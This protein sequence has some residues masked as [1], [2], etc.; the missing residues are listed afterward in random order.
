MLVE[1]VTYIAPWYALEKGGRRIK[2]KIKSIIPWSRRLLLV[3]LDAACVLAAY[4]ATLAFRFGGIVPETYW[5]TFEHSILYIILIYLCV[6]ALFRLYST[7]W[8][9]ASIEELLYVIGA[10]II[11][12]VLCYA[13][14]AIR[15]NRMPRSIYIAAGLIIILLHG[16]L[17]LSY[18][19]F[20]RLLK[21]SIFAHDKIPVLIIGA[22]DAGASII[23]QMQETTSVALIPVCIVDDDIEKR[24]VR[25]HGVRV[26][27]GTDDI[28]VLVKKYGIRQIIYAI[29]SADRIAKRRVLEICTATD[30][31]L[32]II[33]TMETIL[34]GKSD[35]RQLRDVDVGDLLE[36]PIVQ[37]D[38]EAISGY[39][40]GSTVLVTG[41]GGS[42][43]SELCRQ[44]AK[45][46][47]KKLIVF[48]IYENSAYE[49]YVDL[50]RI[51]GDVLDM[52]VVIG[53]VRDIPRLDEVF[54]H[55]KPDVVFHAAAH[56]HVPLMETSPV[57]AVKNNVNGTFNTAKAADIAGVKRFVLIS[58]DKAVNPTNVMGVTKYLCELIV[59]YMNQTSKNTKYVAVRFGNVLDSNGSVVP[60]FRRQIAMGGPVTV[61]HK[62][63]KRYFMTIPEAAQ[64]VI[65]A[66]SMAKRGEIFL[67]DM[68]D[69]VCIDEFARTFIRLSGYEPDVDIKIEYTGLR[70]GEKMFEEL[71]QDSEEPAESGFPGILVGKT[72][73]IKASEIK[74]RIDYIRVMTEKD[75]VHIRK[76]M[77]QVVPT[78]CVPEEPACEDGAAVTVFIEASTLVT[79]SGTPP[80]QAYM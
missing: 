74:S 13:L 76:H 67:L 6:N 51:Y 46:H 21:S 25:V 80:I 18:R 54:G 70:P 57:E 47:P 60:L 42:I 59:Q 23:R 9:H 44:I 32:K 5:S 27:G 75:P 17:R 65:Q 56:K 28:P 71:L 66:G 68:G 15:M 77:A 1:R 36:R 31:E 11:S 3:L 37:L 19:V 4:L 10:S 40:A 35:I 62:D 48:D 53:S 61:T 69:P 26:V 58:T 72:H 49:L 8:E 24:G 38:I 30:C 2:T 52:D 43:G 50:K 34:A 16:G 29:P 41:G 78:Y 14:A 55:Y 45:F 63:I 22:G 79:S 33:P 73:P 64:L 39:L 20:R 7:L 12:T